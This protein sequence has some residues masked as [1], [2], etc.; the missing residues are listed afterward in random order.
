[1]E[2]RKQD[3]KSCD[4]L[5][6]RFKQKFSSLTFNKLLEIYTDF[7]TEIKNRPEPDPKDEWSYDAWEA[8]QEY[9]PKF[10]ALELNDKKMQAEMNKYKAINYKLFT[11][12]ENTAGV[13]KTP[14]FKSVHSRIYVTF[15]RIK[16][17]KNKNDKD[18]YDEKR[19]IMFHHYAKGIGLINVNKV[20]VEK[21][22]Y[23][24]RA[25]GL[26]K[27]VTMLEVCYLALKWWYMADQSGMYNS[28]FPAS[29]HGLTDFLAYNIKE[30]KVLDFSSKTKHLKEVQEESMNYEREKRRGQIDMNFSS[31]SR[32]RRRQSR[33][34]QSRQSPR[35]QS[36]RRQSRRRQS[37]QSPRRQSPRR[38]SRRRQSQRRQSRRRQSRRRQSP[39][40]QSRY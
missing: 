6:D 14:F 5:N 25:V 18:E 28:N 39:R 33:R 21:I 16:R 12:Y 36:R 13:E 30:N 7:V 3:T 17:K 10:L 34:R 9:Y 8:A 37:R 35:R 19:T 40:R 26:T 11:V 23:R 20:P 22:E 15:G 29:C 4:L 38:Q 1:M 32:S 24:I 27:P 31:Q 2:E